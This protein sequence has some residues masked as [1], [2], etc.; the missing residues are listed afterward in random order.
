MSLEAN[1]RR[2]ETALNTLEEICKMT[3]AELESRPNIYEKRSA[4][5]E[6]LRHDRETRMLKEM[7]IT[8]NVVGAVPVRPMTRAEMKDDQT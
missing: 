7:N 5:E 6:I 8:V 3:Q 2:V 1:V 4:A